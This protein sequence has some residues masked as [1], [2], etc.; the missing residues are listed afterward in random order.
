MRDLTA[1]IDQCLG[2]VPEDERYDYLRWR[3]D[4]I[5]EK[6][7]YTAPE[8]MTDRWGEWYRALTEELGKELDEPWKVAISQIMQDKA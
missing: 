5:K 4:K 6:I 2:Q 8:I 1:I 3:A 7:G